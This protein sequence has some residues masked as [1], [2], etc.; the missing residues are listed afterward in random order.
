[1][2]SFAA[3]LLAWMLSACASAVAQL[4]ASPVAEGCVEIAVHSNGFH[5]NLIIPG[6]AFAPAHPLRRLFPEAAWISVGWG[7]EDFYRERG[8]GTFWQGLRA[9]APGGPTVVHVIALDRAPEQHF[10]GGQL[11]RVALTRAGA[12]ELE[13]FLAAELELTET[14]EAVRVALGH[15]GEISAFLRGADRSFSLWNNC[16]HWTVRGLRA[17]GVPVAGAATAD[18][19]MRRLEGVASHCPAS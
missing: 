19:V 1:M 18:G 4:P 15:Y 5:S 11:R 17:A 12:A 9:A 3:L 8:G 7:D 14:G 10:A 6:Q 13:A 2:R 16:N